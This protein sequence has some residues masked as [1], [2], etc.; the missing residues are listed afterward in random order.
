MNC[1]SYY[2]VTENFG[3]R[4]PDPIRKQRL[5][6][7]NSSRNIYGMMGVHAGSTR[8]A[9]EPS[10]VDWMFPPPRQLSYQGS[11]EEVH[12]VN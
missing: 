7:G 9:L 8:G 2:A 3:I 5:V 4:R 12:S 6:N 10:S 11:F 1:M